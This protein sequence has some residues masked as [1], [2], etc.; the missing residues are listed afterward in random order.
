MTNLALRQSF[1]KNQLAATLQVRDVFG[2]MS[3]SSTYEGDG[4]YS[5][6]D[7]QPNTPLV[8]LTLSLRLNNYK[9]DRRNRSQDNDDMGG[10]EDEGF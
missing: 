10:G 3:H 4:F 6:Y 2:T 7:F 5:Y 1:L 8:T 9:P